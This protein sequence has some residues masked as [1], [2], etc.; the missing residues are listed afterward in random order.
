MLTYPIEKESPLHRKVLSRLSSYV[1]WAQKAHRDH[2]DE[3][4]KSE[5]TMMA[6]VPETAADSRRRSKRENEGDPQYTTMV[7]PYSYAV[8]MSAHT[9]F[10]SV[11]L[12]RAPVHQFKGR[13][14]EGQDRVEAVEA[15]IDYQVEYGAAKVPYYS[16]L[17]DASRLGFGVTRTTWDKEI[18]QVAS[19]VNEEPSS[20]QQDGI[21][22]LFGARPP[23]GTKTLKIEEV[24]VYEGN[25]VINCNAFD[26]MFDPRVPLQEFQ[27]G[28]FLVYRI[29]ALG[30]NDIK[31][32]EL[33]GYYMNIRHISTTVG[34]QPRT[35]YEGEN[36]RFRPQDYVFDA[37]GGES[38]PRPGAVAFYEIYVH[39]IPEEFGLGSRQS[40]ELW[41][42][43]VT[44]DMSLIVGATPCGY[45]H[46]RFPFDMV[47]IDPDA[48]TLGARGFPKQLEGVQQTMDWLIN[49]HYFN[50][51][52]ALQNLFLVDPSRVN[53]TDLEDP[54][55]G[56]V[57]RVRPEA[58]GT[59]LRTAIHQIPIMDVTRQHLGELP[60]MQGIGERIA[61]VNDS[62]IGAL[63]GGSKR[64]TA[65][66]VRT[67]TGFSVNRL[68]TIVEFMSEVG[69][70]PHATKMVQNTQQFYTAEKKYRIAGDT[71][72]SGARELLVGPAAIQGFYD[73]VHVDGTMPVDRLAEAKMIQELVMSLVRFPQLAMQYD[74]GK[75]IAYAMMRAGM[76][77]IHQ[78]RVDVQP[79][80]LIAQ[81][82][83]RGNIVPVKT[84]ASRGAN[85][86][87][88]NAAGTSGPIV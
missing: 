76:K 48:Y 58:I 80:D 26:V 47:K 19:I 50:I 10:S 79:D 28:E 86:A 3:W 17:Y 73:L 42:F 54:L 12:G 9:Y 22:D 65:T 5:E 66:E 16:W 43:T 33:Q 15:L 85:G 77:N 49:T 87:L 20:Q 71:L 78:F 60:I 21:A 38:K 25:R 61:G 23:E 83:Q 68:K 84:P 2:H 13:H 11:L 55:P 18:R 56:G 82:L 45:Y 37:D 34:T 14:G 41:C 40:P 7:L 32:K 1:K 81:N 53:L 30:W 4:R 69:V 64:R 63:E 62:V 46:A 36:V 44:Q 51:R 6:Y 27:K 72:V 88:G 31:R 52:A 67:T 35:T 24:E 29:N 75:M 70:G 59:D 57:I 74:I 39:M 8:T